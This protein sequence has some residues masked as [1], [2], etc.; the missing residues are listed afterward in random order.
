M[1]KIKCSYKRYR[2]GYGDY[3]WIDMICNHHDEGRSCNEY[4]QLCEKADDTP[5]QAEN[6]MMIIPLQ[7]V[8]VYEEDVVFEKT[9]NSFEYDNDGLSTRKDFIPKSRIIFLQVDDEVL[10]DE[11]PEEKGATT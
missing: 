8:H 4:D 10:I 7:C 2:C 11:R 3:A 6:G 5:Y 9:T 1:A